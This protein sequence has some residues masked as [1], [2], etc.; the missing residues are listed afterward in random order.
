MQ[1]NRCNSSL[2][3]VVPGP[4]YFN[5]F[6]PQNAPS[7]LSL[8]ISSLD[9]NSYPGLTIL[10][11]AK[12]YSFTDKTDTRIL[13]L[14]SPN[15]FYFRYNPPVGATEEDISL[16]SRNPAGGVMPIYTAP[17]STSG[18]RLGQWVPI[19]F[20]MFRTTNPLITPPIDS[21]SIMDIKL[22]KLA[23]AQAAAGLFSNYAVTE[24]TI[25]GS[26][27]GLLSD[28]TIYKTFIINPWSFNKWGG[29]F[30]NNQKFILYTFAMK[31]TG[32]GQSCLLNSEI[33]GYN[34]GALNIRCIEDYND[35]R[36][37]NNCIATNQGTFNIDANYS[38]ICTGCNCDNNVFCMRAIGF[39]SWCNYVNYGCEYNDVNLVRLIL[40][41]NA[42]TAQCRA[43]N[44]FDAHRFANGQYMPNIVS[45][46]GAYS[47]NVWVMN[48]SYV[49]DTDPNT[50]AF[51]LSNF[52]KL[53]IAWNYHTKFSF[54]YTRVDAL[55]NVVNRYYA[56]C[57]PMADLSKPSNDGAGQTLTYNFSAAGGFNGHENRW[58][59][60]TCGVDQV[61]KTMYISQNNVNPNSSS[62][63]S[64]NTIPSG[65]TNLRLTETSIA[66]YG[67]TYF[68]RLRLWSCYDCGTAYIYLY[69]IC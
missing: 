36:D 17:M 10:F 15:F 43:N 41:L 8:K 65:L 13:I 42:N 19:S 54:T 4:G 34:V 3:G 26:Y 40:E 68:R 48:Q 2:P 21:C 66:N 47:M 35:Y 45:F 50:A 69:F 55:N 12:I 56:T 25:P 32:S 23:A 61:N 63:T 27:V 29:N 16:Y 39:W 58:V 5:V 33:D 52:K 62:F 7:K 44:G 53:E 20:S 46:Q 60:F 38:K 37:S 51:R 31:S 30:N 11:F 9:L 14:D 64:S 22:T 57:Y 67:I 28:I 1:G 18:W 6:P 24:I 59:F 49:R